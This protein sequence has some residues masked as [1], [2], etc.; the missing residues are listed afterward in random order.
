MQRQE[1]RSHIGLAVSGKREGVIQRFSS[2][3][4]VGLDA[5][6]RRLRTQGNAVQVLRNGVVQ[7]AR[8]PPSFF[9]RGPVLGHYELA[10]MVNGG[11]S[12]FGNRGKEAQ[13]G[14]IGRR[15]KG[16]IHVK[17]TVDRPAMKQWKRDNI[18]AGKL[19][20]QDRKS[21]V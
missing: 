14:Y 13:V 11:S 21:V 6:T 18:S 20:A 16:I 7:F 17:Y 12:Q 4:R 1:Q 5:V 8:Q 15:G 19:Q 9:E 2:I 3:R 10:R